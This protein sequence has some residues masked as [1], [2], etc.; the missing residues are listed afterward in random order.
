MRRIYRNWTH[1]EKQVHYATIMYRR[2]HRRQEA[3]GGA[4]QGLEAGAHDMHQHSIRYAHEVVQWESQVSLEVAWEIL[5]QTYL[6]LNVSSV[7]SAWAVN[8]FLLQCEVSEGEGWGHF[9]SC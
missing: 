1:T 4:V 3:W 7:I 5:D 6:E 2:R 9:H 8:D